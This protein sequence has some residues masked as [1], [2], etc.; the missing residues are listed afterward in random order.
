[1][2]DERDEKK[3][4]NSTKKNIRKKFYIDLDVNLV[5]WNLFG[6]DR[7]CLGISVF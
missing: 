5:S 2:I 6:I 1:M 4:K 3:T 7:N